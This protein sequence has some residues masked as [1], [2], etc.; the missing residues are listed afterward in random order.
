M[1]SDRAWVLLK[2]GKRLNLIDPQPDSW[3]DRDLAIGLSRTYRWGGYSRWELPL[4]VAQHS[5]LV[6]VL[7]Q[8]MEPHR[9]LSPREALRELLHDASEGFLSFDPISPLKPHLGQAFEA[10]D[11]RL[12]QAVETRYNLP[13][14]QGD[15]YA[16][17]KQAD[18]LAAA[19]EA[20]HIAGWSRDD[21]HETLN[22]S[23]NPIETDP[24][25]RIEGFAP[26]EPWP[27]Q[28][29][30]AL[31]LSKLR[32]LSDSKRVIENPADLTKAVVREDV[33]RRLASAYARLPDGRKQPC[34]T[35]PTGSSLSDSFVVTQADDGSQT[36]EGVV[37]AGERAAD[38]SWNFRNRVTIF[39]TGEEILDRE[40]HHCL[41]SAP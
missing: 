2:S 14:W 6:L 29:A 25:P 11:G 39:T 1:R 4:S 33:L 41:V 24:L 36:V 20:V 19:S 28:L 32:E 23:L 26:W 17:H 38:G 35:A 18:R 5:V 31:F 10:L 40:G 22:I 7:R 9:P 15:D 13:A 30:A 16:L 27:A 8:A 34:H 12:R 37:I 21:L 3:D